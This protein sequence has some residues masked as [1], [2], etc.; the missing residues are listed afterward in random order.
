MNTFML[1]LQGEGQL[2]PTQNTIWRTT[3]FWPFTTT[4]SLSVVC[5]TVYK[6]WPLQK[7]HILD[8]LLPQKYQN[9]ILLGASVVSISDVRT[10]A[11]LVLM[12]EGYY[13]LR[14]W[15]CGLQWHDHTTF[16]EN[17]SKF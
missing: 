2:T 10:A 3:L 7:F 4:W 12:M 6:T 15:L 17:P 16:H 14:R 1:F 13:K 5:S 8:Y 11:I 9:T